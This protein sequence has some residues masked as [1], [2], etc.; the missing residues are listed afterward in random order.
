MDGKT[1]WNKGE[2]TK[3]LEVGRMVGFSGWLLV[4]L[5]GWYPGC[6]SERDAVRVIVWFSLGPV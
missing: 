4:W 2:R 3:S 6:F 5:S 1:A